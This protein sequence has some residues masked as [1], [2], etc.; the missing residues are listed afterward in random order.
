MS[1]NA[2]SAVF[3]YERPVSSRYCRLKSG[4]LQ[5]RKDQPVTLGVEDKDSFHRDISTKTLCSARRRLLVPLLFPLLGMFLGALLGA[6]LG[7]GAHAY[8]LGF[9]LTG[10][11]VFL[12]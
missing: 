7:C 10:F 2:R 9:L 11:L 6:L 1:A 8:Q 4:V 5:E 3:V 12:Q